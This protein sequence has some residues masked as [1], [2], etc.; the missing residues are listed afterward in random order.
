MCAGLE[1]VFADAEGSGLGFSI[2]AGIQ[3]KLDDLLLKGKRCVGDRDRERAE[4]EIYSETYCNN[5]DA[6]EKTKKD[7][8]QATAAALF[9]H[10]ESL[11]AGLGPL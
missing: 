6:E 7:L 10:M 4:F 5:S 3:R 2:D 11:L 8:A 9:R 1:D